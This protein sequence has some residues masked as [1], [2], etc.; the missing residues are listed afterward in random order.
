[1]T[2]M[3]CNTVMYV[4]NLIY[5][6]CLKWIIILN[7]K[8]IKIKKKSLGRENIEFFWMDSLRIVLYLCIFSNEKM[9]LMFCLAAKIIINK[10][11]RKSFKTF[12]LL[13]IHLLM[14]VMEDL[15]IHFFVNL[16]EF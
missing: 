5:V 11:K 6:L 15:S 8:Y 12:M 1:M 10:F 2:K 14:S 4:L 16:T 9:I 13:L 3:R 7:F